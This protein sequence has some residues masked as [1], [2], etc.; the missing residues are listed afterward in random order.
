M[1][2]K[3]NKSMKKVL[4]CCIPVLH[5][6]VFLYVAYLLEY[7]PIKI[8]RYCAL[9]FTLFYLA[10]VDI[11]S[12]M[13]PNRILLMLL[14]LRGVL[15]IL[16]AILYPGYFA[17]FAFSIVT[18]AGAVMLVL[19][20]G[21]IICKRGMG[22]GDIK[23]FGVIGAYV[24]MQTAFGILFFS[25]AAAALYSIVLLARKKIGAKDEI[26]FAPFVYFG[27]VAASLLGV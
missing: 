21:N 1:A 16:E 7:G 6:A 22:F 20:A 10:G 11:K 24:G 18:G 3:V 25:L 27:F 5:L 9:S 2:V 12:R 14:A 19:L 4:L 26:P 17:G 23:L 8:V 15:L 13:V